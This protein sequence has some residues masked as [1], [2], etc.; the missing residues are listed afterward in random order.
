VHSWLIAHKRGERVA[1]D[2]E[3]QADASYSRV[4]DPW[5]PKLVLLLRE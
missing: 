4:H 2:R 3:G 1:D 5:R